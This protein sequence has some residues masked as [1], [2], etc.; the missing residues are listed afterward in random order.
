[1]QRKYLSNDP[2]ESYRKVSRGIQYDF[3]GYGITFSCFAVSL[4]SARMKRDVWIRTHG[5]LTQ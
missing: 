1:M 4:E 5:G 3:A 2:W